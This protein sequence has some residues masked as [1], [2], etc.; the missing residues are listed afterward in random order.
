M[1]VAITGAM[2][3]LGWHTACRLRSTRSVEPIRLGRAGFADGGLPGAVAEADVILHL[4]GVNR[5]ASDREVEEGNLR[6]AETLA[7]AVRSAARPVHVVYANS[8]QAKVDNAYGRGKARAAEILTSAVADV[9]GSFT[10]VLLP[11]LFGEHGRPGYN[12]FVATF[13]HE[14]AAGR[15]PAVHQDRE[16]PLLHAQ[17]AAEALISAGERGTEGVVEPSGELHGISEVAERLAGFKSLYDGGEIPPLQDRFSVDLFNTYRSATFPDAFPLAPTV[18]RDARGGLFEAVR[19]HGGTGQVFV[20]TTVPGAVRGDHYHLHKIER[21]FVVRGEAEIAL[22][23]LYG[24]EVVRF[25]VS[26]ES[27]AFVDMPTMWVHN[28][29]NVGDSELVTLFWADQLLDRGS[30]DQYPER[31]DL[32]REAV[33]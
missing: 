16:I 8:V 15:T 6:L 9:G 25:R 30:P 4:A 7:G 20:S 32:M 29:R 33:P 23:R 1:R 26:G 3:F 17:G 24:E 11:N 22:R 27:P 5:A 14:V 21:F 31:V 10:D 19:S 12:S 13:C 28:I 18:H 2:G